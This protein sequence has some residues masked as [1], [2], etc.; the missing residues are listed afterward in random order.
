[1]VLLVTKTFSRGSALYLLKVLV[2]VSIMSTVAPGAKTCSLIVN[3]TI[4]KRSDYRPAWDSAV[5]IFMAVN[6]PVGCGGASS[7]DCAAA[8]R[9]RWL[10]L[11]RRGRTASVANPPRWRGGMVAEQS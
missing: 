9:T 1:M 8:T 11:T 5:P 4:G 3:Q 6:L 2:I 10:L 7:I